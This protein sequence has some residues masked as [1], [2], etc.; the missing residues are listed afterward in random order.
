MHD[1]EAD[2]PCAV[3]NTDHAMRETTADF[4]DDLFDRRKKL[5]QLHWIVFQCTHGL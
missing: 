2:K 5:M 1:H 3:N 4:V